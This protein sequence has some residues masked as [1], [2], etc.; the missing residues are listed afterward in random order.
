[1]ACKMRNSTEVDER[2]DE[3][4]PANKTNHSASAERS[5]STR[6][7]CA[8]SFFRLA[9]S[10]AVATCLLFSNISSEPPARIA[11]ASH[12]PRSPCNTHY[13]NVIGPSSSPD[14]KANQ[15]YAFFQCDPIYFASLIRPNRSGT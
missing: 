11:H 14:L 2:K 6:G 8:C 5:E 10:Q 13:V 4:T 9:L 1:C 7:T 12:N 15:L 3:S